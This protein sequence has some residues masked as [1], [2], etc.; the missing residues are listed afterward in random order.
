[1]AKAATQAERLETARLIG[2]VLSG[3][4]EPTYRPTILDG[5]LADLFDAGMMGAGDARRAWRGSKA[6]ASRS[7][8]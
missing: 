7:A 6:E 4:T 8:A 1:M 3:A 5:E 2:L